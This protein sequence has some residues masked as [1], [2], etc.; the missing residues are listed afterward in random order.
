MTQEKNTPKEISTDDLDQAQGGI[1]ITQNHL[2]NPY[3][4]QGIGVMNDNLTNP[5]GTLGPVE[6]H[7]EFKRV[8]MRACKTDTSFSAM[9]YAAGAVLNSR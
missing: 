4:T 1:S 9:I 3:V 6:I 8:A 7:R 2:V 5:Y